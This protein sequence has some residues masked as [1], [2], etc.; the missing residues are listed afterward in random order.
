MLLVGALVAI[1]IIILIV[2]A[3]RYH[4]SG[5]PAIERRSREIAIQPLLR[6][7]ATRA[8]VV[9]ALGLKFVDYSVGSG[10]EW[11]IKQRISDP[12][13]LSR[14][15]RYPGILFHTTD[16]MT[17]L[18]FDSEGRLRDYYLCEQ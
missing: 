10:N 3:E 14:A 18:F 9:D 8:Q 4:R 12:N 11:V 17:W 16:I 7:N 6:S 2:E 13:I 5:P 1:P 15:Q